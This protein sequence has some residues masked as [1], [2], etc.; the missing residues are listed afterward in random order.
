MQH[1]K[2]AHFCY[3]QGCNQLIFSGR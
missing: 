3:E 2:A 1:I